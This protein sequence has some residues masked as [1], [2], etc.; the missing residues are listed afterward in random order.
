MKERRRKSKELFKE[1]TGIVDTAVYDI[2]AAIYANNYGYASRRI[3]EMY[4]RRKFYEAA[5]KY[6]NVINGEDK[7]E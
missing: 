2:T 4:V 3:S 7:K 5:D 1:V 6:V